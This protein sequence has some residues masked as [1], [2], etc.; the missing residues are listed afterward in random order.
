MSSG[1]VNVSGFCV[2]LL[3]EAVPLELQGVAVL[4]HDPLDVGRDA[5]VGRHTHFQRNPTRTLGGLNRC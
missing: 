3:L 1:A 4:G 2:L 5:L